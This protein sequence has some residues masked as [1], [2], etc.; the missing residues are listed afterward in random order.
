MFRCLPRRDS[1]RHILIICALALPALA[2]Q[3]PVRAESGLLS[4]ASGKNSA[5]RVYKGIP[6]AA[7]PTGDLRWKTPKPPASW[8]GTRQA[9]EF[10]PA[11]YQAPY[12]KGSIYYSEPEKMSEDCLYLNLWTAA[13]S[14]KEKRPV[15]VWI[16]GGA[17]TRG[18]GATP[19]YDG[20]ALAAKGVVLVTLNYRLGL[21][22]FLAHP[23]LTK[24]SDRKASG[25]Y[26]FLDQIAAL[27]W[28]HKNIAAFGGDPS[29]VTI[30][31]ESA[32]S[33]S[34][35]YLVATPLAKG[36]FQRAI[37]ESGG[38]F[39]PMKTLGEAEQI[40]AKFAAGRGA[41]TIQALREKPA[42]ELLRYSALGSFPPNVDGWMLPHDVRS[43]FAAGQQND[44]PTL[45]GSNAD[46]ATSLAPWPENGTAA[47]FI[48]QVRQRFGS[49]ADDVLKVYPADSDEQARASHYASFRDFTFGWQM[50]TWARLQSKTG[51]SEAY[52]YYFSR[53]PPGPASK[54]LGA[55]HA[56]ELAYVFDNLAG[57]KPWEEKDHELANT[58]SSY[59][60]NFAKTGDP[61]GKGLP[62]W[63]PYQATIDTAL[64]LGDTVRPVS[65]LHKDAL[66]LWDG[67]FEQVGTASR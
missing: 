46:E 57:T 67:Y 5:V 65:G 64:E 41:D 28:V 45:I 48:A 20:E 30:F 3:D 62:H 29:R 61:N 10:S 39:G 23:D 8:E 17:L 63:V 51:K 38:A 27:E 19:V 32:G 33:W 49:R 11:C 56:S 18:S 36:L 40:G 42:D 50:R 31:G 1:S 25:N 26:A 52:L 7:P 4:G 66:D 14:A 43:I 6:Y 2:I 60:V 58:I 24:E 16:H 44:V 35:N 37:G 12:P 15:M 59:W 54:R 9:L 34:V 53:V 22:G 47:S 55:F 13:K 21:F